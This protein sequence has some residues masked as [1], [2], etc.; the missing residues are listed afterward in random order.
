MLPYR[1][2]EEY[3]ERFVLDAGWS[4]AR[5]LLSG[6]G[7]QGNEKHPPTRT[8]YHPPVLG[9]AKGTQKILTTKTPVRWSVS[10]HIITSTPFPGLLGLVPIVHRTV[11]AGRSSV[12][13]QVARISQHSTKQMSLI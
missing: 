11:L 13:Y 8:L 2:S 12:S 4:E 5:L 7:L 9:S 1:L 10:D 3:G 6:A